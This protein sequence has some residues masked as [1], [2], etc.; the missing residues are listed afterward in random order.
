MVRAHLLKGRFLSAARVSRRTLRVRLTVLY[1]G[2]FLVCGAALLAVTYALVSHGITGGSGVAV[3]PGP[4]QARAIRQLNTFQF[5]ECMR[6]NEVPNYP[7]PGPGQAHIPAGINPYSPV[8]LTAL[9]ACAP[10][11]GSLISPPPPSL[12]MPSVPPAVMR[13]LDT[14]AGQE[15]LRLV[16]TQQQVRE[17]HQLEVE[18]AIALGIMTIL[19]GLLGWLVAGRVLRP[20]RTITATTRDIS[21]TSLN[22]RLALEGP[23]DEVKDLGDTIDALLARLEDS[24]TAQRAFVA[25]ASHE[26]RT[27][28]ALSRAMLQFALAD[29]QLTFSDLKATCQDVLDAGSDHEQLIEALLTLA[30]GQQG[31]EYREPINLAEIVG[32]IVG[33]PRPQG[34]AERITLDTALS[35]AWVSGDPRLIRQLVNNLVENALHHNT[36]DGSVQLTVEARPR[37]TLLTVA[38]TGPPVPA[39]QIDRLLQPFQRLKPD[40]TGDPVGHGLGLSIV[41]AIATAHDATIQIR[42][43]DGGGLHVAVAFPLLAPPEPRRPMTAAPVRHVPG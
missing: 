15:F 33:A 23:E 14:A 36:S 7:Y 8:F 2:M 21:A 35:P 13:V 29:P 18:S 30:R 31:I 16:E 1:G 25:N 41:R 37:H 3:P 43:N 9:K 19:S 26:L 42:P 6:A 17:L 24:F 32:E 4:A 38:N 34:I 12:A 20:L 22:K 10:G 27:P 39:D 40:R 5:A 11:G 28:L